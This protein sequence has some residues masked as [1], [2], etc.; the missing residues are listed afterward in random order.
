MLSRRTLKRVVGQSLLLGVMAL[1][2]SSFRQVQACQLG[3]DC[4]PTAGTCPECSIDALLFPSAATEQGTEAPGRDVMTIWVYNPLMYGQ[5]GR[6]VDQSYFWMLMYIKDDALYPDRATRSICLK[7]YVDPNDPAP[8]LVGAVYASDSN[9]VKLTVH[10]GA[11]PWIDGHIYAREKKFYFCQSFV[12]EHAGVGIWNDEGKQIYNWDDDGTI[13]IGNEGFGRNEVSA[14]DQAEGNGKV[15]WVLEVDGSPGNTY[16]RYALTGSGFLARKRVTFV[17]GDSVESAIYV[18]YPDDPANPPDPK[19]NQLWFVLGPDDV[20]R[21]LQAARTGGGTNLVDGVDLNDPGALC[22]LDGISAETL[23]SY[24][25][26]TYDAYTDFGGVKKPTR[27]HGP[28]CPA[29]GGGSE[30]GQ[31]D[32]GFG[33][34]SGGSGSSGWSSYRR[35]TMP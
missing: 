1:I 16:W 22:G 15:G 14:S 24:A 25:N 3:V 2:C 20:R 17:H 6:S 33:W 8:S 29:C 28:G 18:F 21:Y 10:D 5:T 12:P 23:A 26:I 35:T 34:A 13:L 7:Y 9:A 27:I 19:A 4:Q 31:Y 11:P 32:Y 30:S